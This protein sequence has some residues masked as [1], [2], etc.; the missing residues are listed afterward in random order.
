MKRFEDHIKNR[1]KNHRS[2]VDTDALWNSISE[3]IP[4]GEERKKRGL[5]FLFIFGLGITGGI[6]FIYSNP[7]YQKELA[8]Y[9]HTNAHTLPLAEDIY[10]ENNVDFQHYDMMPPV[11]GNHS[12]DEI[13]H[14]GMQPST[15]DKIIPIKQSLNT[16]VFPNI[17]FNN[18]N[19]N[20][21]IEQEDNSLIFASQYS[22]SKA[23][24]VTIPIKETTNAMSQELLAAVDLLDAEVVAIEESTENIK[25]IVIS[26]DDDGNEKE[27]K[28]GSKERKKVKVALGFTTG[29][30]S[31]KAKFSTDLAKFNYY[32][33]KRSRLEEHKGDRKSVV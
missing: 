16:S 28:P 8:T 2:P 22:S 29:Y 7:S 30:S 17:F 11:S 15:F 21:K 25:N 5:F 20:N 31:S 32:A 6:I 1:L 10:Y 26:N 12:T 24:I 27:G 4:K 23:E 9:F 19:D 3:D 14:Q 13:H 33:S 18:D